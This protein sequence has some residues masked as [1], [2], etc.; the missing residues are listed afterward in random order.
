MHG[1]RQS[2]AAYEDWLR[3]QLGRE[4]V[5]GDLEAKHA[6]M[7]ESPFAFLRATYWRWAETVREAAPELLDAP[8]V[9]AVGDIHL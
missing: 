6:R 4:V 3:R 9:L 2:T 1:I 5:T 7:A 8:D